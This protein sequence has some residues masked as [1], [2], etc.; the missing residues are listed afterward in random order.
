MEEIKFKAFQ[1]K[2]WEYYRA[3][4]RDFPWRRTRD[5]YRIMVSEF[6]LQQ[7]QTSRVIEKYKEFLRAFPT[8]QSLAEAPTR[9]VLRVWQGLGYNR[10]ALSFKKAAE[11]IVECYK[12]HVP[13]NV[14]SLD[15]LPGVGPGTAG[16]IATF[17]F[18]MPV[19]F[20]ETNIRR[21]FIHF[22]FG[23]HKRAIHDEEILFLIEATLD[24]KKP[25]EWYYALMDYGAM[26]GRELGQKNPNQKSA[27]Y[28]RQSR[29][30]GSDRELRGKIVKMLIE[31]S[32]MRYGT[33]KVKEIAKKFKE[34]RQRIQ[35]I[36]V[37][38]KKEGF[39]EKEDR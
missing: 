16:A 30:K 8:V 1:K 35:K 3:N 5:P 21:V 37:V 36:F 33:W 12:G 10:R 27:H 6:M 31:T 9:D 39:I 13:K 4:R 7:T 25:R 11:E 38:L 20:I 23:K 2:I 28:A 19:V 14:E 32:D 17:A 15:D 22:F 26:L 34:P 24:L 18:N 29:F